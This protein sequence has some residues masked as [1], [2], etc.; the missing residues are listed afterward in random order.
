MP[1]KI[2]IVTATYNSVKTL[3]DT[4]ESVLGQTC[5]DYEYIVIDGN[6]T[7][8]TQAL[9]ES[10]RDRFGDRLILVSEPD[11]GLYD[12]MNKGIKRAT[13]DFIGMLNSDDFFSSPYVLETLAAAIADDSVDAVYGDVHYV[14]PSR[15]DRCVRYYSS[16]HFSRGRMR[17]GFMPAHPSFYCRAAVL[18]EF[19]LFDTGYKVAADFE[20]MLRLIYVQRIRTRYVPLDFVTMRTGGISN[21]GLKSHLQIMKDHRRALKANGVWSSSLLLSLR[22]I[23]KAAEV[24][25]SRLGLRT[26]RQPK[27]QS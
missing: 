15:L 27:H 20:Q 1:M 5:Q 23:Y 26:Q 4:I 18:K 8:G 10:Y 17:L 22:Y 7:D 11:K 9:V 19:G 25:T 12:A 6:S 14:K 2:S 13:G 21:A 24:A 3:K 16:R